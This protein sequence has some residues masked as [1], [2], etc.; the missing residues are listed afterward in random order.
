MTQDSQYGGWLPPETPERPP[1]AA[2]PPPPPDPHIPLWAPFL[3]LAAALTIV[4]IIGGTVIAVV[5]AVD[6]SIE[7]DDLPVGL[8]LALTAFQNI[9]FVFAAYIT[10]KLALGRTTR[11]D[12][13]L[14]RVRR[15]GE[16]AG[17]AVL[18]YVGFWMVTALLAGIFGQPE[19]QQLVTDVKNEDSLAVLIAYGVT[20]CLIAP[21]VEELF[22][23]GFMFGAL[24][25]RLGPWWGMAITGVVFAVGHA[26]AP[27][28]SLIALGVFGVGLCLLYW[29]TQSI[30][31]CMALHALNN[32]ITFGVTRDLDP[33]LFAAVVVGAVGTVSA[34]AHA[35]SSRRTVAA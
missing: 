16:A 11:A 12:F 14:V 8:T 23:R 19:E 2:P 22:F 1:E 17:W 9:V 15:I 34:G 30:V 18:V 33:A 7:A 10:V 3:A 24:A 13:G 29:R 25:Q 6:P 27:A 32:A 4:L 20:I 35:L 21:I 28:I 5:S 31:P 26:P